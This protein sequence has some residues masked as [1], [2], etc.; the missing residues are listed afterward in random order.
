VRRPFTRSVAAAGAMILIGLVAPFPPAGAADCAGAV[1]EVIP[2]VPWAQ[3]W[4]APNRIWPL[5]KG[6]SV[7]VAVVDTGVSGAAPALTGAVAPGG[8]SLSGNPD[9]ATDCAGRG[10]FMAG[11]IAARPVAG[12][13]F[14]GLAPAALV[15][16]VRVTDRAEEVDPAKLAKGIR[17]AADAGAQVIAVSVSSG[18]SA[19]L[20]AA[21]TYALSR[22]AVVLAD[23]VGREKEQKPY[24][25]AYEGVIAV[26]GMNASGAPVGGGAIT[27]ALLAPETDVQSLPPAGKGH[28]IA[29]GTG[30]AVAFAAGTAALVRS[31]HPGLTA[32][33][34]HE[35]LQAT[36]DH[37]ATRTPDRTMGYGVVNPYSAVATL[38]P[39]ESGE[40]SRSVAPPPLR[41]DT[42]PVVD[43]QP[44]LIAVL[45]VTTIVVLLC[46]GAI[47]SAIVRH[48]RARARRAAQAG[49]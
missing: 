20:Q 16:P 47:I 42:L 44:D 41:L 6:E 17:H 40:T 14:A 7:L 11:I 28:L 13:G 35:R 24:P 12:A 4:L 27:P 29:T 31:Y 1:D 45:V 18:P 5:T 34:V 25:A 32:A 26:A 33:Q 19:D 3:K 15:L 22:N 10:T 2:A 9:P 39:K 48:H 8:T 43:R 36:A 23:A 49:A 30:I 46:A 38:L 37:P 21:V